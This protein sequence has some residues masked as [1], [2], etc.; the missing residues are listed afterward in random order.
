MLLDPWWNWRDTAFFVVFFVLLAAYVA[1][2]YWLLAT[3]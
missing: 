3:R 1:V 2:F